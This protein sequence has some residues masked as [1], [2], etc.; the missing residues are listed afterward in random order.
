MQHGG[1]AACVFVVRRDQRINP[2]R[3]FGARQL[4]VEVVPPEH[5]RITITG[6]DERVGHHLVVDDLVAAH[7]VVLHEGHRIE[8]P[9][10]NHGAAVGQVHQAVAGGVTHVLQLVAQGE[11]ERGH[12]LIGD[13]ANPVEPALDIFGP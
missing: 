1:F 12:L 2:M 5:A 9:G 13:C 8:R 10:R 7:V 3:R 4:A 6:Q 11:V